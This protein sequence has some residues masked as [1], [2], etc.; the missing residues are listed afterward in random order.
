MKNRWFSVITLVIIITL[1][2]TGCGVSRSEYDAVAVELNLVKEDRQA[3]QTQLQEAQ[4][5][6]TDAKEQL[7]RKKT[8]L[9]TA[10]GQFQTAQAELQMAQTQLQEA[11]SQLN[12]TKSD[13]QNVQAQVL[14]LQNDLD[15][16]RILP[17]EALS[18]AE[19]MDILMYEVWM[20]AG[21]IPNFTFSAAGEYQAT[22]K[23]RAA[24]IGD[25][26]LISFA[27]AIEA[28]PISKNTLYGMC[29]Y[30]L[31]K[32]ETILK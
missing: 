31:D 15:A 16:A 19:F 30:C 2:S 1:I 9:E 14:S 26:Q 5:Q 10:Q 3:L 11:Q 17:D 6:L 7:E 24:S 20:S 27:A 23:N 25:A 28:G 22:L 18:Y 4:S 12:V 29:Y 13:L 32:T 8:D 21:V